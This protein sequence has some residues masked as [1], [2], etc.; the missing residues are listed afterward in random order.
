MFLYHLPPPSVLAL[1]L[2][3]SPPPSLSPCVCF[4]VCVSLVLILYHNLSH[5]RVSPLG[6]CLSGRRCRR[7]RDIKTKSRI[8]SAHPCCFIGCSFIAS[9]RCIAV[10]FPAGTETLNLRSK[11]AA[12]L[13]YLDDNFT[14]NPPKS[15]A[16]WKDL[17]LF[18]SRYINKLRKE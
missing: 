12:L 7:K 5:T 14:E 15:A 8:S 18:V 10:L 9:W 13:S 3:L 16:L 6:D 17:V 11:K 1:S 4:C 2:S